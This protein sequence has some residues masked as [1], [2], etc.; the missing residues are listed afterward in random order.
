MNRDEFWWAAYLT[1]L[2]N[3]PTHT[4]YAAL[5]QDA[6]DRATLAH[7]TADLAVLDFDHYEDRLKK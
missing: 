5:S 1:T 6:D 7:L 3:P 2:N 4:A